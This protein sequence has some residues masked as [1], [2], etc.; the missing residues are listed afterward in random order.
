MSALAPLD[1]NATL[2]I[3]NGMCQALPGGDAGCVW[4]KGDSCPSTPCVVYHGYGSVAACV[5]AQSCYEC[6][7]LASMPS[8]TTLI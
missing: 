2:L 1:D 4:S 6:V 7:P 5:Q 8:V 3:T